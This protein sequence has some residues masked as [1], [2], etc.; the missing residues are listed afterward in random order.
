MQ[1][2]KFSKQFLNLLG[3]VLKVTKAKRAMFF[4]KGERAYLSISNG[5]ML[6]NISAGKADLDFDGDE[7]TIY[8]LTD[9]YEYSK[10]IG[11]PD[12]DGTA[13]SVQ[14]ELSMSGHRY[15]YIKFS[16]SSQ[17]FRSI[18]ADASLF[19]ATSRKVPSTA[20]ND[21]MALMCKIRLDDP[22]LET[23]TKYIKLAP[24]C[25]FVSMRA[26][27][28]YVSMSMKG[29]LAQQIDMKVDP[30]HVLISDESQIA[31]AF[32][33]GQIRMFK[34]EYFYVL[35]G[36]VGI[37]VDDRA[38]S[39]SRGKKAAEVDPASVISFDTD[40]RYYAPKNISALKSNAVIRG[41]SVEDPMVLYVGMTESESA[42]ISNFDMISDTFA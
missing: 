28:E 25:E 41:G 27:D 6:L 5:A 22:T 16:S 17:V 24:G 8:S 38:K 13:I 20:E 32:K 40:F 12:T 42:A 39:E 37:S 11:Y 19:D 18:T 31:T 36:M 3:V 4:R 7:V 23:I 30:T 34:A 9:F 29:K 2:I 14:S 21:P 35:S 10:A 26:T 33:N 1:T 15:E